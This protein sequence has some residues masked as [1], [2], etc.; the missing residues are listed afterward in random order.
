M[1]YILCRWAHVMCAVGL[2]EVKFLDVVK[3]APID[4]SAIPVQRYKLV[5]NKQ[6]YLHRIVI[7]CPNYETIEIINYIFSISFF[8]HLLAEMYILP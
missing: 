4:I 7:A 6:T 3:R 5:S 8:F 1:N 2:P